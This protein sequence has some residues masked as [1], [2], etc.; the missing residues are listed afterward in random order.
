MKCMAYIEV[1]ILQKKLAM[2]GLRGGPDN[3]LG[4]Y[5]I[6]YTVNSVVK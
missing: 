5:N 6:S 2:E 3:E 1:T 4:I